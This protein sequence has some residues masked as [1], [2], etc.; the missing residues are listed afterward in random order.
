MTMQ[1]PELC[2]GNTAGVEECTL[3]HKDGHYHGGKIHM[4]IIYLYYIHHYI[5]C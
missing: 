1:Q 2:Y 4:Y 3:F 5:A